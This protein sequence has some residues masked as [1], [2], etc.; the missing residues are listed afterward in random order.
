MFFSFYYT[1]QVL[2]VNNLLASFVAVVEHQILAHVVDNNEFFLVIVIRDQ[3]LMIL[4]ILFQPKK[5]N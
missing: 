5:Y 2:F 3:Y 1:L 4:K